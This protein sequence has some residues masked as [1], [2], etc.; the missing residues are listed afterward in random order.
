VGGAPKTPN[1]V[2]QVITPESQEALLLGGEVDILDA[3]TLAGLS[4][5][6]VDAETAGKI[7][8]LILPSATWEHIDINL[9]IR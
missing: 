5:T 6:I 1:I 2:I 4:Q 7:K 3:V 9:F 8:T